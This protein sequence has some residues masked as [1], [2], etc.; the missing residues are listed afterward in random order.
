MLRE[1]ADDQGYAVIS[2]NG[3]FGSWDKPFL[4]SIEKLIENPRFD[5]SK[6]LAIGLSNGAKGI[7]ALI[8]TPIGESLLGVVYIS[9]AFSFP[10]ML[11]PSFLINIRKKP[12]LILHGTIDDRVPLNFVEQA[13]IHLKNL[14]AVV[15]LKTW[16]NEDHFLL[17]SRHEELHD[18][19][20]NWVVSLRINTV[21]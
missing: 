7:N 2:L 5:K 12:A 14:T 10:Q 15:Q 18:M 6:L 13:A 11:Q 3:G 20:S 1:I 21:E 16:E 9:P 4:S 19:I 8:A 17:L